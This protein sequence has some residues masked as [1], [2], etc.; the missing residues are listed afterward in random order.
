M[1]SRKLSLLNLKPLQTN[2]WNIYSMASLPSLLSKLHTFITKSA[3]VNTVPA[4]LYP[5]PYCLLFPFSFIKYGRLSFFFLTASRFYRVRFSLIEFY[6]DREDSDYRNTKTSI[7]IKKKSNRKQKGLKITS[8]E[9]K[10][11]GKYGLH[12]KIIQQQKRNR[13]NHVCRFSSTKYLP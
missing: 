2:L 9:A 8:T 12:S 10:P 4:V 11:F 7:V 13:L 3:S 5:P 6:C 1:N